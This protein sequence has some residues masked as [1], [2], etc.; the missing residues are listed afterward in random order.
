MRLAEVD[1]ALVAGRAGVF[2]GPLGVG[3]VDVLEAEGGLQ[4]LQLHRDE[5]GF[6]ELLGSLPTRLDVHVRALEPLDV[7]LAKLQVLLHVQDALALRLLLEPG[8]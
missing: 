8:P 4:Q 5:D 2:A 7:L 3:E 1:L 6:L